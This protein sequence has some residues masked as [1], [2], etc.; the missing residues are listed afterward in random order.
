MNFQYIKNLISEI[1]E[2][3][4]SQMFIVILL[5]VQVSIV[6]KGLGTIK[7]G[8]AVLVLALVAI[9]F[10]SLHARNSDVTLL[11]IQKYGEKMYTRSL[12]FDLIIGVICYSLCLIIFGS[13]VNTFFGNYSMSFALNFFLLARI[14]QTF[15]E[16]SKAIL[17][18]NGNF[19]KFALVETIS[20]LFRFLVIVFLFNSNASIDN[21]LIG[22]AT[23]SVTYGIFSLIICREYLLI[24]EISLKNLLDYFTKFKS[25]FVK[26]RYDQLVGIIPQH[27]D[28]V[29]LGYFTDFSTVGIFR[30]AK[31]LIEPINYIVSVL[32]PYVQNKLSRE[33]QNIRFNKLL[34]NILLPISSVLLAFY[35]YFGNGLINLISGPSFE[36]AYH[37]LLIL[38]IGYIVYLNTFWVRQLLL[39]KNLI[40]YHAFSR[41]VSLIV[42]LISAFFLSPAYG[43][44]GLALALS[45]GMISQKVYEFYSYRRFSNQK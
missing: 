14:T 1:K 42:F 26:Q 10:R 40:H 43:A 38:L 41:I 35:I 33:D 25:D 7:Y 4:S 19:K 3:A 21:Y 45:L 20:N 18:Y 31:R 5:F 39:F 36:N 16:S 27:F 6:T 17:T 11:M 28:L 23:F 44:N 9:I 12:F 2:L 29:I 32:T 24:S 37:P 13:Q 8:Q 22:H 15:S 34:M 30:I